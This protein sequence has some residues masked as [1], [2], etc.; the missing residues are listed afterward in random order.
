ME[1]HTI[2]SEKVLAPTFT[3]TGNISMVALMASSLE[4]LAN[5]AASDEAGSGKTL[6]RRV[7]SDRGVWFV[8]P[9]PIK[10]PGFSVTVLHGHM[11]QRFNWK[12]QRFFQRHHFDL[13]V[14]YGRFCG[15]EIPLIDT[16][17][18]SPMLTEFCF[19]IRERADIEG[20]E[21]LGTL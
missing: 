1:F 7:I 10:L 4:K 13:P 18:N 6:L 8:E 2:D 11:G 5:V 14:D 12:W 16:R 15:G 9:V 3:V 20:S 17:V 19:G 21:R